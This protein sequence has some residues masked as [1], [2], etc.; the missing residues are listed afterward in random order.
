MEWEGK[1]T[2]SVPRCC[3]K[4]TVRFGF[5]FFDDTCS[6]KWVM[7]LQASTAGGLPIMHWE[8]F[9]CLF[10]L[11][12]VYV[13]HFSFRPCFKYKEQLKQM[14]PRISLTMIWNNFWLFWGKQNGN[15][16]CENKC[17][18]S[19]SYFGGPQRLHGSP[20]IKTSVIQSFSSHDVLWLI[21]SSGDRSLNSQ[22]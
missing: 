1:A 16:A 14:P 12:F 4:S 10:S 18:Y 22:Q 9:L 13:K 5:A 21:S 15:F 2:P 3:C 17:T 19:R 7:L 6:Q 8:H 20:P 11:F